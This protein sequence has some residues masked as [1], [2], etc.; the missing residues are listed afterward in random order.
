MINNKKNIVDCHIHTL[1]KK[2]LETYLKTSSANKF[3]N[4]RG[5]YIDEMLDPYD[6]NEFID[7]NDM[8]FLDSVDLNNIEDELIKVKKDI[9]KYSR[10][11]GIKIYLGY[12]KYYANDERI[13][14]VADF[15]DKH[16]LSVTFHCGEIYDENGESSYSPFSDAKFMEELVI[17]YPNVNFVASHIN[18]PNFDS[19]FYMCNKYNN[20]YTCF[21]GCNDGESID[22]RNKQNIII[23]DIINKYLKQYPKV[24]KKIMYGTDF[25]AVSD[26]YNDVSS[27]I[28][29]MD[30]LNLTEEEKIDILYNNACDAYNTSFQ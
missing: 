2:E 27:Y 14:K 13:H 11:L 25:F 19:L 1:T 17:K 23:S 20:V 5:L 10:I 16:G 29:I 4:I 28:K 7:N 8:Y 18:W 21:S 12:Q 15:A 30:L 6:F 22:E 9:T 26:E 24:K 3:I